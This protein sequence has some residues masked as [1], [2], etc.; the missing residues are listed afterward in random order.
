M[1]L[2]E[3]RLAHSYFE[4]GIFKTVLNVSYEGIYHTEETFS[5]QKLVA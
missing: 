4:G 5:H 1:T 2:S 3:V